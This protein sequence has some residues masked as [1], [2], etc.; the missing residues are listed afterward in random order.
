MI[1]HVFAYEK[2]VKIISYKVNTGVTVMPWKGT[3]VPQGW[4]V[5]NITSINDADIDE[6]IPY[7]WDKLYIENFKQ[8][9][10]PVVYLKNVYSLLNHISN[11]GSSKSKSSMILLQKLIDRHY[12]YIEEWD[13]RS[14]VLN[15]FRFE[16]KPYFTSNPWVGALSNAFVI[17]A[18]LA[19]LKKFHSERLDNITRKLINA[20]KFPY[21]LNFNS[22]RWI[23]YVDNDSLLWFDEYPLENGQASLVLNGHIFSIEALHEAYKFYKDDELNLLIQAG[24]TT[25]REKVHLFRRAG[26]VNKYSLNNIPKSDYLPRRTVRQQCELYVLTGDVF[27]RNMASTFYKDARGKVSFDGSE[28]APLALIDK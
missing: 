16:Q 26:K 2:S 5:E 13:D 10:Q 19:I 18:N 9:F 15:K 4:N 12:Q 8:S 28:F 24:I 3:L 21:D 6:L 11:L 14:F 1:N 22:S 25:L 27:F 17:C 23:S 7:K 20:F